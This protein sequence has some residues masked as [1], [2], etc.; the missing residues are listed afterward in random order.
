MNASTKFN[1]SAGNGK[2]SAP[3]SIGR[4]AART[5][6]EFEE[7]SCRYIRE[8]E[9][10]P[11]SEDEIL[12]LKLA[13]P[14]MGALYLDEICDET[15]EPLVTALTAPATT[16]RNQPRLAALQRNNTAEVSH[17]RC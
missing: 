7:A 4:R 1:R 12:H 5:A 14:H 6:L 9:S 10:K 13:M 8:R 16:Q 15:L 3:P 2:A 17:L 11:S